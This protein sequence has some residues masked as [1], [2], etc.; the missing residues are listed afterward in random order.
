MQRRPL[1]TE[2]AVCLQE[3]EQMNKSLCQLRQ[4]KG[5]A[6]QQTQA[7]AP[8]KETQVAATAV[9]QVL[10]LLHCTLC[11]R[12]SRESNNVALWGHAVLA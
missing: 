7:R 10:L 11:T 4:K 3:V 2:V 5:S 8:S 1:M 6:G 12:M 9:V